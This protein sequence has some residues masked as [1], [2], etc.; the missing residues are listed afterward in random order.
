MTRP[1][2]NNHVVTSGIQAPLQEEKNSV[3]EQF[4]DETVVFTKRKCDPLTKENVAIPKSIEPRGKMVTK[5]ALSITPT[6]PTPRLIGSPG[7]KK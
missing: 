3:S 2:G 7:D 4:R 5:I 6:V 1:I